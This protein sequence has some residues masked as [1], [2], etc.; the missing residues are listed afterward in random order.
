MKVFGVGLAGT[1]TTS[2]RAALETLGCVPALHGPW[3][4][5]DFARCGSAVGNTV[6]RRYRI[7]CDR[8]SDA[9]FVYTGRPMDDW[10]RTCEAHASEPGTELF[11]RR[12]FDRDAWRRI[13]L[14]HEADV[15]AW[16]SDHPHRLLSIDVTD[17]RSDYE[18]WDDIC[19]LLVATTPDIPFP[20]LNKT[21]HETQ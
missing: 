5:V 9:K 15:I 11:G 18:K 13:Y 14:K 12:T 19:E 2:L 4:I 16:F 20:H 6:A 3:S 8:W 17:D 21:N 7:L 10:L 1:G